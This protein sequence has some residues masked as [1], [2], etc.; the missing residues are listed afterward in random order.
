MVYPI[1]RHTM[2]HLKI[3]DLQTG[4]DA[5]G[6]RLHEVAPFLQHCH[7]QKPLAHAIARHHGHVDADLTMPHL[8]RLRKTSDT[9]D[10]SDIANIFCWCCCNAAGTS[11]SSA[12]AAHSNSYISSLCL[13]CLSSL[14]VNAAKTLCQELQ[15][16]A[17]ALQALPCGNYSSCCAGAT[18]MGLSGATNAASQLVISNNMTRLTRRYK[19]LGYIVLHMKINNTTFK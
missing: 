10:S 14:T 16:E 4:S 11:Q 18:R 17:P 15:L 12:L 6:I 2:T 5:D 1:F 3:T 7:G 8:G 9:S 19:K 13:G